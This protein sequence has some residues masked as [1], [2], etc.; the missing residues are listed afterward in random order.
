[1]WDR[2]AFG[3]LAPNLDMSRSGLQGILRRPL[4]SLTGTCAMHVAF[5]EQQAAARRHRRA[6]LLWFFGLQIVLTTPE[7]AVAN[8][9]QTPKFPRVLSTRYRTPRHP[10]FAN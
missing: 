8:F 9:P 10:M 3:G 4:A 5:R 7:C 2:S 1:M 6:R